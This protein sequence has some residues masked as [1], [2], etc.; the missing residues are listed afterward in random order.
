MVS[1]S[2]VI[3]SAME[4]LARAE[5]Q[6]DFTD[7]NPTGRASQES[8]L[9][10]M[11][12]DQALLSF[13]FLDEHPADDDMPVD[14]SWIKQILPPKGSPCPGSRESAVYEGKACDVSWIQCGETNGLCVYVGEGIAWKAM[15]R[16]QFRQLLAGLGVTPEARTP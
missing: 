12:G 9:V 2:N 1:D 6:K 16:R 7:Y 14:E 13:A 10:R 3:R 15:T 8:I 4:R 11:W 5:N